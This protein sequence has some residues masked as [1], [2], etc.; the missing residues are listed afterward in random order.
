MKREATLK[1][2][3]DKIDT[4]ISTEDSLVWDNSEVHTFSEGTKVYV[5]ESFHGEYDYSHTEIN[6]VYS[7]PYLAEVAA[8]KIRDYYKKACEQPDPFDAVDDLE[9]MTP[10]EY[11]D[12][13]R[14][15]D[16]R[17]DA[18]EYKLTRVIQYELNKTIIR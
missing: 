1:E 18:K 7:S 5:V 14:L 11:N 17:N 6:G 10:E 3:T 8:Q 16:I 13:D 2:F 15:W 9:L 12:C 4:P